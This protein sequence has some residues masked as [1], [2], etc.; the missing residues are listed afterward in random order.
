VQEAEVDE[1][2]THGARGVVG[3]VE[4][5]TGPTLARSFAVLF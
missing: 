1:G 3:S 5:A 2:E 4:R